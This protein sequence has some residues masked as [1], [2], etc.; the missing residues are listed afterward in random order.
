ML[1]EVN[2]IHVPNCKI[3]VLQP[4]NKLMQ[5]PLKCVSVNQPKFPKLMSF[6]SSME[7]A[8]VNIK[9]RTKMSKNIML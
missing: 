8:G 2:Y 1:K 6:P 3:D 5:K 4:Y 7:H 9:D